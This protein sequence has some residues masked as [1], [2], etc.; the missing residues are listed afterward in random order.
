M[1]AREK[2]SYRPFVLCAAALLILP[3]LATGCAKDSVTGTST[4]TEPAGELLKASGCKDFIAAQAIPA[5]D[6]PSMYYDCFEYEYEPGGTLTMTHINAGL[7]CC[8]G[9]IQAEIT[10]EAD[11]IMIREEEGPDA[12]WCHCLC[13][14]DIEYEF[15]DIKPGEYTIIFIGKYT[16]DED[17]LQATVQLSENASDR[18]CIKRNIYPWNTG[19]YSL[20]EGEL[21][22]YKGC[23]EFIPSVDFDDTPRNQSCVSYGYDGSTLFLDHINAG[24]NC[25]QDMIYAV[26]VIE[27]D[28]IT[29]TE[30]EDP[31]GGLCDCLCLFDT[32]YVI[33]NLLPVEYTVRFVELYVYNDDPVLEFGIDLSSP[34]S[35]EYCV[36]RKHYPWNND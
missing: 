21:I 33:R 1:S 29:I 28:I 3:F 22:D 18:I 6:E 30:S 11:T 8:P 5:I 19:S 7:N 36:T 34:F 13:L 27:D 17:H 26:I 14:Y 9:T 15:T 25:C 20:P 10:I 4:S 23:K 2:S 16:G 31:P 35:G 32:R 12:P 24:F